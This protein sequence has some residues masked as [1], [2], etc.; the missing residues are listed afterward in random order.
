MR[1][2]KHCAS[3]PR[4]LNIAIAELSNYSETTTSA[5]FFKDIA[6]PDRKNLTDKRTSEMT[7]E[8]DVD[9]KT[10]VMPFSPKTD[11]IEY[12]SILAAQQY[13]QFIDDQQ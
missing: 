7:T 5:D 8:T 3:V 6:E 9:T 4:D 1:E 2:I 10:I 12:E 11:R 13:M